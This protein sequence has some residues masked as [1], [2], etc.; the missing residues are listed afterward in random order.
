MGAASTLR[1]DALTVIRPHGE[2]RGRN[3]LP[4]RPTQAHGA[5]GRKKAG[6]DPKHA[7]WEA[8]RGGESHYLLGL[9]IFLQHNLREK[10]QEAGND[11]KAQVLI[12]GDNFIKMLGLDFSSTKWVPV[13]QLRNICLNHGKTHRCLCS[14]RSRG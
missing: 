5:L 12:P 3:H 4:T 1:K 14:S 2:E 9:W 8:R 7:E 6:M 10:N 11:H 13:K